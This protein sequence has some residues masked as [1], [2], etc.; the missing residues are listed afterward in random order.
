MS[1]LRLDR[2]HVLAARSQ[3]FEGSFHPIEIVLIRG[4]IVAKQE[5]RLDFEWIAASLNQLRV[6]GSDGVVSYNLIGEISYDDIIT[7]IETHEAGQEAIPEIE[8]RRIIRQAISNAGNAGLIDP[9]RLRGELSKLRNEYENRDPRDFALVT[10]LSVEPPIRRV[11]I[12]IKY[13]KIIISSLLP[14]RFRLTRASYPLEHYAENHTPEGYSILRAYVQAKSE[15]HAFD[16]A[17]Q[18]IDLARGLW[19]FQM[20]HSFLEARPIGPPRPIN[21]VR[22]GPVHTLHHPDGTSASPLFWYE[23]YVPRK[24][25]AERLG[26]VELSNL[27]EQERKIK[28]IL[29][30]HNYPEFMESAFVR[31]ARSLDGLDYD[32]CF[33]KL[34]SVLEYLVVLQGHENYDKLIDRVLF[35]GD[36]EKYHSIVL[37]HLKTRRNAAVHRG[38]TSDQAKMFVFQ[39]K[40]YVD[41]LLKF[42]LIMGRTVSSQNEACILMSCP[43]QIEGLK[44]KVRAGVKTQKLLSQALKFRSS[45]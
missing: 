35:T 32:A 8:R 12:S 38:E 22:L 5:N 36:D 28:N 3:D 9:K 11:K 7:T 29:R 37:N 31:Y 39:L 24:G 43:R 21:A 16:K 23:T 42:H 41:H 26:L 25:R 6:V 19:N 4:S 18:A 14:E 27:H 20:R 33:L 10:S 40:R 34:W 13:S 2:L 17:M 15:Y 30:W 44:E 1:A 45:E